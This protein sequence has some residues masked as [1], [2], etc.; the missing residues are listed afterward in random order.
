MIKI[1]ITLDDVIRAKTRQFGNVYKKN[2][3][4]EC[5]IEE[6]NFTS[7]D[8]MRIFNFNSKKEFEKF[9]YE[10]YVFEIFGESSTA[11]PS[12]DKKL[13]LWHLALNSHDDIEDELE[14]VLIS[15]MEFN[16]S[17]GCTYFFLSKIASRV[18]EV[19]FPKNTEDAWDVCDILITADPK[20]L[21]GVRDDKVCIKIKTDYNKTNG[22]KVFLSFDSLEEFLSDN[23][24]LLNVV[25]KYNENGE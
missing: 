11:T 13:N 10:D 17:I 19:H 3:D 7:N 23:N 8:L 15:P 12:L 4:P 24:N 21:D 16:S 25:K 14:I 1:G 22:E 2:V 18:R 20:L 5:N 6:L 9:L